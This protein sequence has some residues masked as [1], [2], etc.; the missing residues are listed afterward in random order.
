M[1]LRRSGCASFSFVALSKEAIAV[2]ANRRAE[3]AAA[4]RRATASPGMI[5]P[6]VAQKNASVLQ[7]IELT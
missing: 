5:E 3:L 1:Q 6:E 4:T 7:R 2:P